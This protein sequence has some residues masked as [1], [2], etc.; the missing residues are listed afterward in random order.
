G[1]VGID[2]DAQRP[3]EHRLIGEQ[4]VQL[5][6]GPLAR[7]PV[8]P[9]LLLRRLLAVLAPGAVPDA[10]ELF[11]PDAG[12]LMGVQDAFSD[13][14]VGIQL[15]PSLSL[16]ERDSAP[17]GR[18]SAFSLKTFLH[19]GVMVRLAAYLLSAVELGAVAQGRHRGQ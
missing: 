19:A 8:G 18:A 11:E 6:E 13:R 7:M 4:L 14:M 12:V 10:R 9:A 16:A 3:G 15:Q 17:R 2:F 5:R 1:V